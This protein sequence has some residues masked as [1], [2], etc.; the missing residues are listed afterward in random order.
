MNTGVRCDGRVRVYAV[1][2]Y[3]L[4]ACTYVL[5]VL[6]TVLASIGHQARNTS[7]DTAKLP[8]SN[9]GS[10]VG[11]LTSAEDPCAS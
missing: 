11:L 10:A 4:H 6:A 5:P 7:Q 8:G 1:T 2:A 9:A 3:T